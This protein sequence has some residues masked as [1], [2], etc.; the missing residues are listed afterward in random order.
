MKVVL[1]RVKVKEYL[2]KLKFRDLFVEV[3]GWDHG[4]EDIRVAVSDHTFLLR[5]IAHKRGMV[6]YQYEA[7]RN[8][9]F[10]DHLTRQKIEKDVSRI[11]REHLIVYSS[12]SGTQYWQWVKREPGQPDRLRLHIFNQNQKGEALIQRLEHLVFTIDEEDDLTI[13]DV[14]GR[15][16]AAFDVEKVTKKFYDRFRTEH[17]VFL[18]SIQ[19]IEN[20]DDR[21]W[22]ASLMLNRMM[23][24]YFIQKRG[25]LDSDVNYL[26]NRL[27]SMQLVYGKDQ[28]QSFYRYFLLRLFHEGLSQRETERS[29]ELVQL[30]GSVPYLNGGLFET[31]DLEKDK[32]VVNIPDAAFQRIFDFFDAY[33]WYLDDR[34][35]HDDKEINP[36]VLGYIFEKYINQ[37]QMGAYYTKED[38]TGYIS[39]N[40]VIPC[41]F[42]LANKKCPIAFER[43]GGVWRLL[44]DDPN[45]YVFDSVRHG[46]N[47]DI[48]QRQNLMQRRKLPAI[49][50]AGLETP[51]KRD[52]W[53]EEASSEFG[54][55]T[56]SWRE[57][58]ARRQHYDRVFE[59]LS[60]GS[61]ES[62]NDLV[63]LNL[64]LEKF[65]Y[66]VIAS[67]EGP[68]LVRAFWH[69]ISNISILDPT[70][71]SGAFLFAALNL[72]EPMYVSCI[73]AM[74]GFLDD[75]EHS[76]R[77]HHPESMSDFRAVIDQMAHY[78]DQRSFILKSIIV[79][80][81]YG[82]D[83]MKEA[84]EICKLRLFLKLVA[85]VESFDQIEPLPDIDFNIR[86]GNTVVGFASMDH[87][88][89]ALDTDM[90]LEPVLSSLINRAI[91]A[92]SAFR[93]FQNVQTTHTFE[94]NILIAAKTMLRD[95]LFDLRSDLDGYLATE[96]GITVEQTDSRDFWRE[97][98]RPFHWFVEF[99]EIMQGGGFD[100]IIGNPPYISTK[101]VQKTYNVRG[102]D[103]SDC[104]DVYAWILERTQNLLKVG[105]RSGMIVP[106]SIG[107]S[108]DFFQCRELLFEGFSINW[109]S[110]FGRIP[111]ALF[112]FDV[113]VRNTIHI[114]YKGDLNQQNFTSRLHRWFDI[115]RPYLFNQIQYTDFEPRL[116]ENRIPKLNSS[117]L[118]KI[119]AKLL[120]SS[121]TR[122]GM[123]TSRR[124]TEYVLHS[125]KTA[126]NWLNF[127][128]TLPPCYDEENNLIS[129][130]KS[131]LVYFS[132]KETLD[133]TML[134]GNGK[135]MLAFWFIV[136]D[137]F[138]VT[139]WNFA[140]FPI[141][142]TLLHPRYRTR[143]LELT[144]ELEQ[145]M[146]EN[147][148]YKLNAKKRIG[149]YNLAKC[150][151]ITD[152][153]DSI[154]LE[155]L[156][157]PEA[158]DAI[159]LCY[160]QTVK[161][162][163]S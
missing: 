124:P 65:L 62:I 109:F 147:I 29:P 142:F 139:R 81:L 33:Q 149:N 118:S 130:P 40:T 48:R 19:G 16:R 89:R 161:T 11:V 146:Q 43:G 80:N 103:C 112:S 127:C 87:L 34:P 74:Q 66:D 83:I 153:S 27:Q 12:Y 138:H 140:E 4:G 52:I 1:D 92:E 152:R 131:T 7:D 128:R 151:Q 71:G 100:V 145:A 57:H 154:F 35:L 30:L 60:L 158:W 67:S 47:F 86:P 26:R 125:T 9:V 2:T 17:D 64:D 84:V 88:K 106:L 141:D 58:I 6:A 15:V 98:H 117:V 143:L 101:I 36:D 21:E 159:E 105:G 114:G 110:S 25:F 119:F 95:S 44:S 49:V 24:I 129:Q 97:T 78:T 144:V 135:L 77:K 102:F 22:Y 63:T 20:L 111:S 162:D 133:L 72:L 75:L 13:V 148:Q 82:V 107:F 91:A 18:A 53:D 61:I 116:W 38:I 32:D 104:P 99:H 163:F 150:R 134:L 50:A 156:G 10:P 126:Y 69:A 123:Q 85:Q 90:L 3:L 45:R 79:G 120:S 113:R 59:K 39:K 96:Y 56:E 70:C 23:F 94:A 132:D 31:H 160:A 55:P 46:I 136:S 5:A 155:A 68:E 157:I 122:L 121:S 76:T 108:G 54:L 115:T 42:D 41:L 14:S 8:S 28:F 73:E 37:K 93:Q 137:D 51:A